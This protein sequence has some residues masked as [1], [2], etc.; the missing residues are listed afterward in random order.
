MVPAT[1]AGTVAEAVG[2]CPGLVM[3]FVTA[4]YNAASLQRPRA[5]RRFG[6][7]AVVENSSGGWQCLESSMMLQDKLLV[8][9]L[10]MHRSGTSAVARALRVLGVDLGAHL[11]PPAP[12]NR[13][14][15]F[16]D[17]GLV[18]L[19]M[20][21]MD[22]CGSNWFSMDPLSLDGLSGKALADFREQATQLL[23]NR[24][25]KADIFGIKDPRIC[26][27]LPFWQSVFAQLNI[28]VKYVLACRSPMSVADSLSQRNAFGREVSYLLW[29]RHVFE[30]IVHTQANIH[31]VLEY[32][33][34]MDAPRAEVLRLA[35]QLGLES[36]LNQD[37]LDEYQ[38]QFLD[39]DMRHTRYGVSDVSADPGLPAFVARLY[40]VLHQAASDKL[41]HPSEA[42]LKA[43]EA[44]SLSFEDVRPWLAR[45]EVM[46]LRLTAA[47]KSLEG[48]NQA[49]SVLQVKLAE[50]DAQL[51][52]F[53][54]ALGERTEQ[55][56]AAKELMAQK[57]RRI[58]VLESLLH[59]Q[60][61][62]LRQWGT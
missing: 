62:L 9:V 52:R 59:R 28:K 47:G 45:L 46:D 37:S 36:E 21:L 4:G 56:V 5:Q 1:S 16:E 61:D 44:A 54:L 11:L 48:A 10:G 26:L 34:L 53:A 58:D 3:V 8:V 24:F 55:L 18:A 42:L 14:G 43:A 35:R 51:D 49:A 13:K 23:Q 60:D 25:S 41:S 15:F 39:D 50:A 22:A 31:A 30:A 29:A 20:R 33:H 2:G 57:D 32:D 6:D 40:G 17:A 12:D 27:L 19:N 7:G 38:S